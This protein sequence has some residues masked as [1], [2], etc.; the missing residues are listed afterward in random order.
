MG[1]VSVVSHLDTEDHGE[2]QNVVDE[3]VRGGYP[4]QSSRMLPTE[5]DPIGDTFPAYKRSTRML[6]PFIF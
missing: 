5:A 4:A 3:L 6:I 2:P 1:C